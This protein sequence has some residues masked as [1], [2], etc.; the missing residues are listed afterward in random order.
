MNNLRYALVGHG[1]A[2]WH[3]CAFW[4]LLWSLRPEAPG[5]GV[6]A[7][8]PGARGSGLVRW[9]ADSQA[10]LRDLKRVFS[11][12]TCPMPKPLDETPFLDWSEAPTQRPRSYPERW[13]LARE[14]DEKFMT[15]QA[16]GSRKLDPGGMIEFSP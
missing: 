5:P 2:A 4:A 11:P 7:Q 6:G 1:K 16:W 14:A 15:R 13:R 9:D 12:K 8:G 3:R 10:L